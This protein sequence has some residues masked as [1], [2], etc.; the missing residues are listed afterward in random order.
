MQDDGI[1]AWCVQ[2]DC[3][4]SEYVN[5][6]RKRLSRFPSSDAAVHVQ[7]GTEKDSGNWVHQQPFKGATLVKMSRDVAQK[8]ADMLDPYLRNSLTRVTLNVEVSDLMPEGTGVGYRPWRN[9]DDPE[10]KDI[11]TVVWLLA[12]KAAT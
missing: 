11:P 6:A 12:P 7:A 3:D 1:N 2:A 4:F 8:L 9:S 10:L 5:I